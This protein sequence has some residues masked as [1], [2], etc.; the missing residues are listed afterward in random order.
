MKNFFIAFTAIFIFSVVVSSPVYA[1]TVRTTT[2]GT[3]NNQPTISAVPGALSLFFRDISQRMQL[4]WTIDSASDA[5]LRLEFATD[6]ITLVSGL[7]RLTNN[8]EVIERG[9]NLIKRAT[10]LVE[11]V[12][13]TEERWSK[14]D[15]DALQSIS[16]RSQEYFKSAQELVDFT[17]S[18]SDDSV[19][20][21]S[22]GD[23]LG[24]L[25]AQNEKVKASLAQMIQSNNNSASSL[26]SDK[27][28]DGIE[29]DDESKLG[30]SV[31][32]YDSDKDGLSDKEE[33]ERFGTDPTKADTDGDGYRD[34]V[35]IM[36]GFNPVG[37]G[38][39]STTTIKND[40]FVFV[41]AKMTLPTLSPATIKLL[42]DANDGKKLERYNGTSLK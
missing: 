42:Q 41:K 22:L 27:D 35:E 31:T 13:K 40:G 26:A 37:T 32:D 19:W 16:V 39:F 11:V 36:K 5:A 9:D 38:N 1:Q 6:N 23:T 18:L 29:D 25:N 2:G 8:P 10:A 21:T 34:G 24:A 20:R 12:N 14:G 30:L 33:I 3:T 15:A 17:R 4:L 28:N 7:M